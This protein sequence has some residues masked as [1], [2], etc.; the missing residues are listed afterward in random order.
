MAYPLGEAKPGPLR[1]K[2]DRRL[3]LEIHGGELSSH[4]GLLPYRV[5]D[6]AR[7]LAE[8]G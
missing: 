4:G 2:I 7:G 6:H 1:A 8:W 5:C 3:N